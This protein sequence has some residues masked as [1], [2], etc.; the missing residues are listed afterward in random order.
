M[1][2]QDGK[3]WNSSF[4]ECAS[5]HLVECNDLNSL[6]ELLNLIFKFVQRLIFLPTELYL[7]YSSLEINEY[8]FVL[9][10]DARL[11]EKMENSILNE[12]NKFLNIP[13]SFDPDY[14]SSKTVLEQ[15]R[16]WNDIV[17]LLKSEI[18][19]LVITKILSK[20]SNYFELSS[21]DLIFEEI[22]KLLFE[23]VMSN[24]LSPKT[25]SICSLCCSFSK[26]S[27]NYSPLPTF[28]II[29]RHY[30]SLEKHDI[31]SKMIGIFLFIYLLFIHRARFTYYCI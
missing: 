16:I 15:N 3:K 19:E 26:S 13:K 5:F 11:F 20:F 8:K 18:D 1:T 31:S 24:D 23:M 14:L 4:W 12:F 28:S 25:E 10:P 9:T 2:V 6:N 27:K 21:H 22:Y 30:C 17:Y 29:W 7:S